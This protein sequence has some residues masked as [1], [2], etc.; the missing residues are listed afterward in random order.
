[1]SN[2]CVGASTRE[3]LR[4][5]LNMISDELHA[6]RGLSSSIQEHLEGPGPQE[7]SAESNQVLGLLDA[8]CVIRDRI[9]AIN[10]DLE[11]SCK[12]LS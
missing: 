12:L 7:N 4:V 11:E 5:V 9:R 3:P 8:A 2:V 6:C 1:M 10:R